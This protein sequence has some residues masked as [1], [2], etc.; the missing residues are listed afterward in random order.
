MAI[1]GK[2]PVSKRIVPNAASEPGSQYLFLDGVRN[3]APWELQHLDDATCV[4][5][6]GKRLVELNYQEW[7][8]RVWSVMQV[9]GQFVNAVV[10]QRQAH[11]AG[12]S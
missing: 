9:R 7:L 6:T 3:L 10:Q 1:T 12:R 11:F 8:D 5:L 4:E 2:R